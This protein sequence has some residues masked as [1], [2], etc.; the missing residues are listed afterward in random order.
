MIQVSVL[1][2][3][4]EGVEFDMDY[5]TEIHM[6]LVQRLTDCRRMTVQRGVA[7]ARG[8]GEPSFVAIGQLHYDSIAAFR[9]AFDTHAQRILGDIANFTNVEP[10]IQISEE[11]S[12]E[13]A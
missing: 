2:P 1:Y 9:S 8:Q 11:M 4:R 13:F 7:G 12:V 5:Y 6:P 3:N 10:T